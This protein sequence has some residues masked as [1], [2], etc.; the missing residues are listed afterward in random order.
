MLPSLLVS[1]MFISP[2]ISFLFSWWL[3]YLKFKALS[4]LFLSYLISGGGHHGD[5][6]EEDASLPVASLWGLWIRVWPRRLLV[7]AVS[8]Q[9]SMCVNCSWVRARGATAVSRHPKNLFRGG[10]ELKWRDKENAD[11]RCRAVCTSEEL[12]WKSR[13]L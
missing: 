10:V 1:G 4:E 3:Q 6:G 12:C 11:S 5:V 8:D 7:P 9:Q 13:S 2:A